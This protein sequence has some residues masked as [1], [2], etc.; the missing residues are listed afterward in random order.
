MA[1]GDEYVQP[2]NPTYEERLKMLRIALEE[3]NHPEDFDNLVELLSPPIDITN[4]NSTGNCK[5]IKV[6]II[7]GG[8]AGLA[9]AFELRK[10]GFDITI[11]E[12]EDSR[13]GGRIYTHY[14]DRE[15]KLYGEFGAMRIPISHETVW[16]Y[17]DLL[18]LKTRPFIQSN[19]NAFIYVR[20]K[21]ARNDPEGKSVMEKIYPEFNLT[22]Q[23]RSTP[24]QKLIGYA[25]ASNLLKI[26]P[27]IRKELIQ[28][29][30]KYSDTIE[31]IDSLRIREVLEKM[32]LS[33]GAIEMLSGIVPFAGYFYY[34]NYF[35]NLQE[36]Y[37]V[38]YAYRYEI[39]DGFVKMPLAFYNSLMKKNPK[40]YSNIKA[41]DLG[42][43]LWKS[44]KTVIGIYKLDGSNKVILRHKNERSLE[45][46]D[47]EFDF[48][49][50]TIPFSSLRTVEI[51]PM[52]STGKMQA[53]KE[54]GYASSQKTVFLCNERFW[55]SG[56]ASEK[57]IGGG[58][59]TDEI[60]GSIWYDVY[61]NS[62]NIEN[63]KKSNKKK[64]YRNNR[65]IL[66]ASYNLNQDALR[67]GNLEESRRFELI[68]RQV[69]NVHGLQEGELDSIVEAY[70]T[71]LWDKEK[72]FYGGFCY[73]KPGQ[74][75]LFLYASAKPEYD[76]RVYFAG[77]HASVSHGWIQGSLSS[78]MKAANDIA[79]YCKVMNL[80]SI[81]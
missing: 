19:E 77:E 38:D 80:N 41:E 17:I 48:V 5:G 55:E 79:E 23:E 21:R 12:T 36:E 37:T 58:S 14:F 2:I 4:I 8:V 72:G 53:I 73:T 27:S 68:K 71:V 22:P 61:D 39:V 33:K 44:G 75:R 13:I 20:N 70:K 76:N 64:N 42:K 31:Y 45:V 66:L 52:F 51:N 74:Q 57:I 9:S 10:L 63:R 30:E 59:Y 46:S 47:E 3:G 7:G 16:H 40:E 62:R 25:L 50:C 67:L 81:K 32:G 18:G 28:I 54:L 78:A 69:E 49:I 15:K 29:K 11:F 24:W 43:V 6:G 35:E 26:D 65:G 34:N 56:D 1:I 60:I